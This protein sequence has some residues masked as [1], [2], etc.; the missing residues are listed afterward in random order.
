[1]IGYHS[2]PVIADAML[3]DIKGF[4]YKRPTRHV[5]TV[6]MLDHF[7]TFPAYKAKVYIGR[8]RNMKCFL[9]H[10]NM[11]YD[12]WCIAVWRAKLGKNR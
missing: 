4:D 2:V 11:P 3:K 1:M 5:N 7:R 9:K 10:W 6:P 8:Q 12:D